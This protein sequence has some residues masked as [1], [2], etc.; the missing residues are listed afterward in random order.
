M[1]LLCKIKYS[2]CL[3][4]IPVEPG[5]EAMVNDFIY[6]WDSL[7][8]INK[9]FDPKAKTMS[10]ESL[11]LAV[12]AHWAT[13]WPVHDYA[14]MKLS[15]YPLFGNLPDRESLVSQ[16]GE[17][18]EAHLVVRVTTEERADLTGDDWKGLP[19]IDMSSLPNYR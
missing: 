14:V 11:S 13:A 8:E 17:Y 2:A 18:A 15:E 4:R 1:N 12:A 16:Y 5:Y 6:K 10:D 19:I 3:I 7:H 9:L